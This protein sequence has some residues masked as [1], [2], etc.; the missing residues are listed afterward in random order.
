M[1]F[2]SEIVIS[3]IVSAL[4]VSL[5]ETYEFT[6]VMDKKISLWLFVIASSFS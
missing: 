5:N 2:F 1:D 6:E 3:V 4:C